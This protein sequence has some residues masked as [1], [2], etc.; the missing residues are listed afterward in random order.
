MTFLLLAIPVSPCH[1]ESPAASPDQKSDLTDMSV[2][3]L[4]G[5][6]VATVYGASKYEQQVTDAP[7]SV[8]I[9]TADDIKR[10]GYRTLAE[11]LRSVRGIYVTYDRTFSYLGVRG[12]D[13]PGDL[14]TRVLLLIDGHRINDDIYE[15]APIG[16]EFPVDVDLIER[17]EVIRGPSSSLY[18][19]NA[20]FGVINVITK[21][22][23][24]LQGGEV[25]ASA[26]GFGTYNGRVSYGK[27]Y[28][29]GLGVLLSASGM[30]SQGDDKL[31]Y[32]EFDSR[33]T[34][35]IAHRADGE[36]N[37]QLFGKFSYRDF[38]L[39]AAMAS[40]QK[41][42]PTASYGT[43][44]NDPGTQAIEGHSF[45][46]LKYSHIFR[47]DTEISGRLFYDR[48]VY[49]GDYIYDRSQRGSAPATVLNKDQAWGY[50]WG[51][52]TQAVTTFLDRNKITTGA[53]Y[54]SNGTQ[55]QRNYDQDPYFLHLDDRRSSTIW[56][57]YLQDEIQLLDSLI[58]SAGVRYDHYDS[59]GGTTNPR[60]ALI[61]KPVESS[62]FKLLY[63]RAFRAPGAYEFYYN[64][65]GLTSKGNP[66]LKPERIQTY[67]VVYEQYFLKHY[68]S[69]LSG[70][71]YQL[72]DLVS[73][74]LDPADGMIQYGNVDAVDAK[75]GEVELEGTWES[76]L[77]GKVSYSYTLTRDARTDKSLTNSPRHLVKGNIVVPLLRDRL[78]LGGE[79][80]YQS[81]R[82]TLS[83]A[84]TGGA[85]VTN[86]T[87]SWRTPLSGLEFS[88]SA[89]NLF[90]NRYSDPASAAHVQD[91]IRQD[92]R[93]FRVKLDYLF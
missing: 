5:V 58:L 28:R 71:Y 43:L 15:G 51:G 59:F 4:M 83:G 6:E 17:I 76:G 12:F 7:A 70:F 77:K 54:R 63:G 75:G 27:K 79:E 81:S 25:A 47:G 90:N 78:F 23:A 66:A 56:A 67:E 91:A 82:T 48:L 62:V 49:D 10:Y 14:N 29:S 46:D 11:A 42:I 92:G 53:E 68:R 32:R 52:E 55:R 24:G 21:Q 69:S 38:I 13:R 1:A 22:P 65:G 3:D 86:A 40:R 61:Y 85:Y 33:Y 36:H 60:L 9:V 84:Q 74:R 19:T 44:F 39:T 26:G 41:T 35:G 87:L 80:Q 2:E 89:Y 31:H 45:L 88:L 93:S 18:G 34:P 20:F 73:Q 37:Y 50:W 57:L 64:D 30:E 8:S 16:M 72:S